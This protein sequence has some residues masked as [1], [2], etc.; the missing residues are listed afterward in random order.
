M[1]SSFLDRAA[2]LAAR[3]KNAELV[4]LLEPQ[5]PLYR[6]SRRF[7]QL[8][9]VACLRAGDASGAHTYLK[10]ADQL[11]PGDPLTML[12][13]AALHLRRA[14][15]DKAA[16]LYL[17]VLERRPR[18]R[19]AQEALAFMRRP[20]LA[21][22]IAGMVDEGSFSRF[23]PGAPSPFRRLLAPLAVLLSLLLVAALVVGGIALA[24]RLR[25]AGAARPE[26]AAIGLTG[27]ERL[28]PVS[29]GGSYRYVLTEAQALQAF[30]LAKKR[31]AEYRDNAALVEL[32]RLLGSNAR[33]ALLDKASTLKAY[34]ATPDWRSIRDVPSFAAV[35]ADPWIHDGV[36]VSWKGRAANLRSEG[37]QRGFDFLAGYEGRKRLEGIVPAF[38]ADQAV[39]L[40][41]ERAFE[42]LA[43]VR[44]E[45]SGG[46][47]LEVLAIHEL[48]D[49]PE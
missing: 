10:R 24:G 21:E 5:L 31:F 34:A 2:R 8:L 14:E 26:I 40:P 36:A 32:N 39:P 12:G 6:D 18:D 37:S 20:D 47:R 38:L 19:V 44:S 1:A 15:T 3:G 16:A 25:Q 28:S 33:Q 22:R 48:L 11:D 42:L 45:S 17:A 35:L 23:Y 4:A 29:A 43:I 49:Q 13:L 41:A 27:E 30:D 46:F 7:Y 9:G